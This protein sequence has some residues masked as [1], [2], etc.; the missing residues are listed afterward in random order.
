MSAREVV[1]VYKKQLI[2]FRGKTEKP[3]ELE[4]E[5]RLYDFILEMPETRLRQYNEVRF[6]DGYPK[7]KR[8]TV[9]ILGWNIQ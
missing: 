3:E 7:S 8:I 4:W 2:H 1:E 5:I 6:G 9:K